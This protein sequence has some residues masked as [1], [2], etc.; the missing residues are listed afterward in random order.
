MFFLDKLKI[1]ILG[2]VILEKS[3]NENAVKTRFDFLDILGKICP[4]SFEDFS[5]ITGPMTAN[6][7]YLERGSYSL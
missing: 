7:I 1:V 5:L 3:L 2:C 6:F 4:F